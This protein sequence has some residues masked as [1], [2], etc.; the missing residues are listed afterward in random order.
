MRQD[1]DSMLRQIVTPAAGLAPTDAELE[2]LL[3]G[4]NRRWVEKLKVLMPQ[5]S[6]LVC[7]GAGHLPGDKG[8]IALLRGAGYI[9]ESVSK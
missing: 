5:Q 9:V 6:V 8:L 7:V 1:L 3:W 2:L 4:R